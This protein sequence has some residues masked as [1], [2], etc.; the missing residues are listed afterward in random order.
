MLTSEGN[1]LIDQIDLI[2]LILFEA[3][4]STWGLVMFSTIDKTYGFLIKTKVGNSVMRPSN[5]VVLD[6]YVHYLR[7]FF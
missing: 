2:S 3:I 6:Y 1:D 5:N 4:P 7:I